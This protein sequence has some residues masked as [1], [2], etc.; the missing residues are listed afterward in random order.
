MD[1]NVVSRD[2]FMVALQNVQAVFLWAA[3]YGDVTFAQ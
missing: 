1:G 3:P 2:E